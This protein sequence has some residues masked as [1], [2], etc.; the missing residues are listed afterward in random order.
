MPSELAAVGTLERETFLFDTLSVEDGLSSDFILSIEQDQQGFIWFITR[1]GINRYDGQNVE[2]YYRK[3]GSSNHPDFNWYHH[4]FVDDEGKLWLGRFGT[5]TDSE[6]TLINW[7]DPITGNFGDIEQLGTGAGSERHMDLID[8]IQVDERG[9]YIIGSR[10]LQYLDKSSQVLDTIWPEKMHRERISTHTVSRA[11]DGTL[12]MGT[13]G[14]GVL[15]YDP[16]EGRSEVFTVESAP[17]ALPAN[18]VFVIE[19]FEENVLWLAETGACLTKVDL[20]NDSSH[21]MSIALG[22]D[23][24]NRSTSYFALELI[25][26]SRGRVWMGT[27]HNGM[28]ILNTETGQFDPFVVEHRSLHPHYFRANII[29]EDREGTLWVGTESYGALK[30]DSYKTSVGVVNRLVAPDTGDEAPAWEVVA[31]DRHGNIWAGSENQGVFKFDQDLN[32]LRRFVHEEGDA[33]SIHHNRATRL[34]ADDAGFMWVGTSFG[35]SRIDVTSGEVERI[36][37]DLAEGES[38]YSKTVDAMH[39]DA[40][41]NVWIAQQKLLEKYDASLGRL[42][43]LPPEIE[44]AAT[45][46]VED[47]EVGQDGLV[48]LGTANGVVRFDPDSMGRVEWGDDV[49]DPRSIREESVEDLFRDSNDRMWLVT[50]S[51]IARFEGKQN[52]FLFY[53]VRRTLSTG[54]VYGLAEDDRGQIWAA[55]HKGVIRYLEESDSFGDFRRIESDLGRPLT[56]IGTSDTG[57]L[58]LSNLTGFVWFDASDVGVAET[59]RQD[60]PLFITRI[61]ANGEEVSFGPASPLPT[62][63]L[64]PGGNSLSV[65]FSLLEFRDSEKSVFSYRIEELDADWVYANKRNN[66]TYNQLP[67]GKYHLEVRGAGSDGVWSDTIVLPVLVLPYFWQTIWFKLSLFVFVTAGVVVAHRYMTHR[68]RYRNLKLRDQIEFRK[69][70]E[71]KLRESEAKALAA[72]VETEHALRVAEAASEAKSLFLANMSHEI[73][74]PLNA[75]MGMSE[76]LRMKD[77]KEDHDTFIDTIRSSSTHLLGLIEGLLNYTKLE[78]EKVKVNLTPCELGEVVNDVIAIVRPDAIKKGIELK[79]ECSE[80]IPKFVLAD[81]GLLKQILLNLASNAVKYT[82]EGFVSVGAKLNGSFSD[83]VSVLFEIV[84]SGVGISEESKERVFN[85]FEQEDPSSTRVYGGVGL[86]LSIVHKLTHLLGGEVSL[87][88]EKGKGSRFRVAIDFALPV[89][90]GGNQLAVETSADV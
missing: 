88:S 3:V 49:Y 34:L 69:Q 80:E 64:S 27:L 71:A 75:I 60:V 63:E 44:N 20:E 59:Q 33:N 31:E 11:I 26:D 79:V 14:D 17:F 67:P 15:H 66:A 10:G 61:L 72:K 56:R 87:E 51:G 19:Q 39:E 35:A 21:P 42:V 24:S 7:Y 28:H 47:I 78:S 48:W 23:Q 53:D 12:W 29:F 70:S 16:R 5:H 73:R 76:L 36:T 85:I 32:F 2:T 83:R 90:G 84:D 37:A 81:A 30:I 89:E 68:I 41:G 43:D 82:P 9:M 86:G 4:S 77:M 22:G 1:N 18:D 57:R 38:V 6:S 52:A 58:M 65:D 50:R 40:S 55:T 62:V 74:T 46:L 54:L 45:S 25:Q 8:A 13:G